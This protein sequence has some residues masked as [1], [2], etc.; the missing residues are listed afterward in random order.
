MKEET[1][2]P[3]K[4]TGKHT[5]QENVY[6]ILKE[7]I[8]TLQL[9][10]GTVMSTQEMAN[11]LNVSRTPVR[12]T[13]IRLQKEGL[14]DIVPQK[15]TMVSRINLKRVEEERFIRESLELAVVEPFLQNCREEHILLM[16]ANVEKQRTFSEQKK[17]AEFVECDNQLHK[18]FFDVADQGLSWKTIMNVNGHYN[19]IRI[20]TVQMEGVIAS[21]I[22]QHEKLIED[23]TRGDKEKIRS[24]LAHH[25]Q[26]LLAEMKL[27]VKLYPEYFEDEGMNRAFSIGSL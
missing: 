26:K 15:E 27:L 9:P 1:A 8:M 11:K 13:F 19:R 6:S 17:Y 18:I 3:M 23:I 5:I 21:A 10:P 7:G 16:R 25:V 12:E 14:V 20:L 22:E 24:E 2:M 4:D